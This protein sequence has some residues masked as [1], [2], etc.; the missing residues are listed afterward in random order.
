MTDKQSPEEKV[1]AHDRNVLKDEKDGKRRQHKA[2][3]LLVIQFFRFLT[4]R[5]FFGTE[6]NPFELSIQV[7]SFWIFYQQ[8]SIDLWYYVS[9][10]IDIL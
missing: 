1:H 2:D 5:Y 4:S 9:P 10:W 3:N 8:I 7:E 6:Y